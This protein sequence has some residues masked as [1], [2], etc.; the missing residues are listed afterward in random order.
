MGLSSS[1]CSYVEVI[2]LVGHT[3]TF[4]CVSSSVFVKHR[5]FDN[6]FVPKQIT[7]WVVTS[8]RSH[9]IAALDCSVKLS[10]GYHT[11]CIGI[12]VGIMRLSITSVNLRFYM[13]ASRSR[14]YIS[15]LVV[16]FISVPSH[17][18]SVRYVV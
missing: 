5:T 9:H 14:T 3:Y 8:V 4:D 13:R 17:C 6:R 2:V 10:I 11:P 15:T 18:S 16:D 7:R 12:I 1:L